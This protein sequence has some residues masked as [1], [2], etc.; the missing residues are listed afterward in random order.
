[1]SDPFAEFEQ[2]EE[3][4]LEAS[5]APQ[6]VSN[7]LKEERQKLEKVSSFSELRACFPEDVQK[8]AEEAF[9]QR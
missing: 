2:V 8:A 6:A 1:M 9:H 7:Y 3:K 5:D 4:T